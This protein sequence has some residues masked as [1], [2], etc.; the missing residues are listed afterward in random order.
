MSF[1]DIIKLV[2]EAVGTLPSGNDVKNEERMELIAACERM[3]ASL[4]SPLE[5][6]TRIIFGVNYLLPSCFP[7]LITSIM[8]TDLQMEQIRL[9]C[10][11]PFD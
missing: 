7:S 10:Q 9:I 1:S 2:N 5:F 8:N 4:E 6:V 11:L 3:K